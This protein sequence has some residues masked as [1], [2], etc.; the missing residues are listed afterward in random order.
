MAFVE[1]RGPGR[2][3]ARYRGPDGRER[4]RTFD[5]RSD[6]ERFLATAE[7]DK[8]RGT[9]ID[10]ALGRETLAVFWPRFLEASPHLR[11]T[12]RAL[13]VGLA[14]RHVLPPP[15]GLGARQVA[16]I[17]R[18]DVERW[19][20]GLSAAG[21]GAATVSAAHRLLR[22][23][24]SLAEDGGLV[25]RNVARGVKTAR[26]GREEMRFLS[27]EEL[28]A[29]ADAAGEEH[30]ALVLLLGLCGLRIGEAAALRVEDV[31]LL[32]RSV[33]VTK[34]AADVNGR[35]IVGPTKTG[36]SRAVAL[37]RVV[38]EELERHL[39]RART[40]LVFAGPEGGP[41]R[42]SNW[43]RRVWIPALR[44][45]GVAEPLPRPHDLRHTAAALGIQAGA[46]PKSIQAMLGH[47]SI[48]V[49]LDRYGH[50]FP[51]L[52]EGLADELDA[53]YREAAAASLRPAASGGS[54]TPIDSGR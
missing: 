45:A 4:S 35:I 39:A 34:S 38:A 33:R 7:A 6:A 1:K 41:L 19:A 22:R 48:R 16:S 18:L 42:R 52:A 21:A 8:A 30:R 17:T 47:S 54:V 11:P 43:R 32:R 20:A 9:W 46:H 53:R 10:P 36:A 3:R 29:I 24:L 51:S 2:W 13:Y 26:P 28:A 5:R 12:T 50:L 40:P 31:D 27:A 25:A 15:H 14:E 49:T 44:R 23:I 37:P